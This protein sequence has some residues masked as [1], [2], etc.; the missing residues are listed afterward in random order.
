MANVAVAFGAV[1]L[2]LGVGGFLGSGMASMTALIPAA[3]GLL[4]LILGLIARDARRR[5]HAMHAAA[6]VGVLGF[7]GTV[8]G[9]V[10]VI[11]GNLGPRPQAA[12]AQ[13]AMAAL[14]LVFVV[15][16]VRSFINARRSGAV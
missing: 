3:F 16:C 7:F 14:M 12:M 13:A 2:I 10:K 11:T 6:M 5:R 15:L 9:L 8:S 1:L 4:L